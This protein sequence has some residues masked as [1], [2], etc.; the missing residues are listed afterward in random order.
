MEGQV[1]MTAASKLFTDAFA[2]A[3]PGLKRNHYGVIYADVPMRFKSYDNKTVVSARA[4]ATHAERLHYRTMETVAIKA[5]PVADLA[6]KDC[7]LFYWTSPPFLKIALSIIETW[8][9]T[10]KTTAFCW[11]KLDPQATPIKPQ[12]GMGFWTRSNSELVLLATRGHPKRRHN[13]VWQTVLEPRRQHS[14]K[15][16]LYDRI[17]RLVA[18]PYVELFARQTRDGWDSHGD[19]I[20][21]FD[22]PDARKIPPARYVGPFGRDFTTKEP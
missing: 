21:C 4:T 8:G 17:E 10:Y 5:L 13:D 22:Q 6:A 7:M 20:H 2:E 9:F 15:P 11:T 18:G 19:Q 12:M 16:D 14:R 3:F 1:A